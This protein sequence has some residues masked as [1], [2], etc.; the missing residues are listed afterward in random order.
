MFEDPARYS[1]MAELERNWQVIR[2]ERI[3]L[4]SNGFIA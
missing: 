1:F 2:D 3:T 4:R